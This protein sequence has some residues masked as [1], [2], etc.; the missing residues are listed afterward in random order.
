MKAY[1]G[2]MSVNFVFS[3]IFTKLRQLRSDTLGQPSRQAI[4]MQ[5][6]MPVWYLQLLSKYSR[7]RRMVH[8][9]RTAQLA[10][11]VAEALIDM[12]SEDLL[13]GKENK[14]ILSLLGQSTFIGFNLV[15]KKLQ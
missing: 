3:P 5:T 15:L 2:L 8:A 14:D 11:E 1:F 6:V 10:N 12:K 7:S 9:R 4:F 13:H